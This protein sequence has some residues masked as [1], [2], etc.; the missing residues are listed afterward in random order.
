[1]GLSAALIKTHTPQIGS[2]CF[3]SVIYQQECSE[4]VTSC[5][6][7]LANFQHYE[8]LRMAKTLALL[9][10]DIELVTY[11]NME[12]FP[13]EKQGT[14]KSK[15]S[16]YEW[17]GPIG[18]EHKEHQLQKSVEYQGKGATNIMLV[19]QHFYS[20]PSVEPLNISCSTHEW[21]HKRPRGSIEK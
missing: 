5:S 15:P 7:F 18:S 6:C 10:I 17:E 13:P 8:C 12:E 21:C 14:G 3:F 1:M 9:I 20:C 16:I 2:C 4:T 19:A 11:G